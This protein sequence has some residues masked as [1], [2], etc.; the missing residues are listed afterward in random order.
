VSPSPTILSDLFREHLVEALGTHYT[1]DRELTGGGMSR[2]F[3]ARQHALNR[4][5]V[6]KVLRQEL[7]LFAIRRGAGAIVT[8]GIYRVRADSGMIRMSV[9]D[10]SEERALPRVEM[11]S[12]LRDPSAM[13]TRL[14]ATLVEQLGQVNWGPKAQ[15]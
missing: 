12:P 4:T 2:V 11:R 7:R 15:R 8:A 13:A 9:R 1:L 6:V 5:V 14:S 10:M 3:V